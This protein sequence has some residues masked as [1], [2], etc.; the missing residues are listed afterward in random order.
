MVGSKIIHNLL[1]GVYYDKNSAFV[2]DDGKWFIREQKELSKELLR[3]IFDYVDSTKTVKK[4]DDVLSVMKHLF[5]LGG[6]GDA[7][8][9]KMDEGQQISLYKQMGK[10]LQFET[11]DIDSL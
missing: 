9:E 10:K 5:V 7:D 4:K 1:Q 3:K 6:C 8:I 11:I 2:Y